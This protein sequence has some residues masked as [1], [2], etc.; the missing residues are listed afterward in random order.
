MAVLL[1]DRIVVKMKEFSF[2]VQTS[3]TTRVPQLPRK[4]LRLS[5]IVTL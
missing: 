4:L 3:K 5:A 2:N 1:Y